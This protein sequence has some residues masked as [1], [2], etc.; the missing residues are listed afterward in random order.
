M[1]DSG[2]ASHKLLFHIGNQILDSQSLMTKTT[3][4][5]A[6]EIRLH[7]LLVGHL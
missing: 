4:E 5:Q 2:N 1:A 7:A 3:A 6:D